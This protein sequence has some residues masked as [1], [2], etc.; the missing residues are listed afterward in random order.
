MMRQNRVPFQRMMDGDMLLVGIENQRVWLWGV[1]DDGDKPMV[2]E[3]E[4]DPGADWT[5]TGEHLDEFLWHFTLVDTA[6][7][8]YGVQAH[9]VT[10]T[11]HERFTRTWAELGVKP[12]RWP[13]P[14]A[15]VWT[16]DR[17]IAWTMV[18]VRPEAPVTADS[19]YSIIVGAR[20]NDDLAHVDDA[21]ISWAWD[22]R[23]ERW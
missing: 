23:N 4:N 18:N 14:N 2:W 21:G 12:W 13:G 1:H 22:S 9:D 10:S 11:D 8:R 17:L 20:S 6:F 7:S 16:R 5:E 19:P 15:A 3:R